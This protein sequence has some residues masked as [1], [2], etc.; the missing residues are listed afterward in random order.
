MVKEVEVQK[1][2]FQLDDAQAALVLVLKDL[3]QSIND[4]R[5]ATQ[6]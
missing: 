2:K 5:R 4:L 6:K 1:E 3:I